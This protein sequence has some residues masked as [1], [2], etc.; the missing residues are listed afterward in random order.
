VAKKVA[1]VTHSMGGLVTRASLLKGMEPKISGIVHTVM[2]ADGAVVAYRRFFTGAR[3]EFNDGP[4]PF[5][6]ILGGTR[7]H[8]SVQQSVLRGPTELLPSETYPDEFFRFGAGITN[9]FS[10]NLYG[11]YARRETPGFMYQAGEV[12]ESETFDL[13]VDAADV[14][15]LTKRLDEAR[16]FMGSISNR[17]HA[18]TILM[19]G[20]DHV[21]DQ[22][23]DFSKGPRTASGENMLAL[24]PQTRTGDGTVP[25]ASARAKNCTTAIDRVE[26]KVPHGECFQDKNFRADVI[27]QL[28]RV[29][30]L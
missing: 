7:L 25:L 29:L 30:F 4:G 14:T 3:K 11:D 10:T 27:A 26:R 2:P 17:F 1:I 22:L 23:V 12:D 20:T 9:K 28:R 16:I 5:R 18:Q 24:S 21:T 6:T 8:Y 15:N 13:T 19:P